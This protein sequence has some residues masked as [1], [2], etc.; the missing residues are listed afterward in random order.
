[1]GV[2]LDCSS[3]GGVAENSIDVREVSSLIG[4]SLTGGDGL[5][6]LT[7]AAA[8]VLGIVAPFL[9]NNDANIPYE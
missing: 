5:L 9:F 6:L 7:G 4:S 3:L 2:P 1:L 8:G